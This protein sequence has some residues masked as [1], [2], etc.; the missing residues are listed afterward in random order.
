MNNNIDLKLED[1]TIK[2]SIEW[3]PNDPEYCFSITMGGIEH[4]MIMGP[5][6]G[7][8]IETT[9][10]HLKSLLSYKVL[11]ASNKHYETNRK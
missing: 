5:N 4:Y 9:L 8:V 1:I 11:E 10:R 7:K 3:Y 6:L 2:S